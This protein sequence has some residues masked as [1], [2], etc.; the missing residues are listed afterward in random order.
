MSRRLLLQSIL[1][2]R[3]EIKSGAAKVQDI[4]EDYFKSSG[5]SV[6]DEDRA[7][8]MN[9]FAEIAPTNVTPLKSRAFDE[10]DETAEGFDPDYM[11]GTSD[12]DKTAGELLA[13]SEGVDIAET[14]LPT[15]NIRGKINYPAMED[16]LGV[17]LRGNETF[18]ELL[19][20]EKNAKKEGLGS[21]FPKDKDGFDDRGEVAEFIKKMREAG[22]KNKDIKGVFKES[23]TDL[24]QGK[25]AATTLA[26]AA[27]MKADTAIKQEALAD[28]DD[29]IANY[30]PNWWK[31]LGYNDG[32][33][34]YESYGEMSRAMIGRIN[35]GIMDD[36][37]KAG[38]PEEKVTEIFTFLNDAR[39]RLA[40]DPKAFVRKVADELEIEDINY[41]VSFWDNYV[42]EIM[43]RIE[44]PEPRFADGGVV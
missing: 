28:L 42:D 18:D 33:M 3:D 44:K 29:D 31:G 40:N 16:K 5:K 26:R 1:K 25:K 7:I 20:I 4:V 10:I 22:I 27:D 41:D 6:T 2:F 9:E 36:L 14:I 32:P 30:G 34:G 43:S 11:R 8:I 35:N 21:L 39:K 19:E 13:E 12:T 15:G 38:V 17:K 24:A 37:E 23:G